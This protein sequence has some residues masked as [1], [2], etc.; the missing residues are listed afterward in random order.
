MATTTT[1]R[2]TTTMIPT[3]EPGLY[4]LLA[5]LSPA[6]PVGG[7]S[8][9]HGLEAAVADG[10]VRGLDSLVQWIEG[11]IEFGAGA[12]DAALF[13]AAHR[14]SADLGRLVTLGATWR[15]TAELAHESATQG[16]AFLRT[17]RAAWPAPDLDA[18]ADAAAGRSVAYPVAVGVA[19]RGLALELALP[20][21]LQA[22][23]ANLVS[24]GIRLIPL[25]QT[26]GVRA[27]ARLAP[28]VAAAAAAP[29]GLDALG[30]AALAV[31]LASMAHETQH[32]RLFRT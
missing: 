1:T 25:G 13:A 15:G 27:I 9:S 24:A 5:W 17:V 11:V 26:D 19:C 12:V 7:F 29:A 32:T 4:R 8:F 18:L 31:D 16:D 20:A 14:G 3:A 6:F 22:V 21:F 23:A 30:G 10:V 2:S 28:A